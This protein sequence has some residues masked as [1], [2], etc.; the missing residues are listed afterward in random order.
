LLPE[1]QEAQ[2]ADDEPDYPLPMLKPELDQH[3]CCGTRARL[4]IGVEPEEDQRA[5]RIIRRRRY[6]LAPIPILYAVAEPVICR[7]NMVVVPSKGMLASSDA[8]KNARTIMLNLG[9]S[10]AVR[11]FQNLEISNFW[12][13]H[14]PVA[15]LDDH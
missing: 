3:R 12:Q 7:F 11:I 8:I 9:Q 2:R 5:K 10:M 6:A 1:A 15:D 13:W 4:F 14:A